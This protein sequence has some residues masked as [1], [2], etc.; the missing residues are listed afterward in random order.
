MNEIPASLGFRMPAEWERHEATWIAW[1]HEAT[2][3]PGKFAPIAW[4][5]GEIV[6]HLSRVERVRILVQDG[7]S[8][9]RI[10]GVL[11]KSG[12]D[13]DAVDFFPIKTDRSWT[14]DYCPIFVTNADGRR[15][16]LNWRFNGWAKYGNH[17]A[18]DAVTIGILFFLRRRL[19]LGRFA[20]DQRR[21]DA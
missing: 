8:E 1:P 4:V 9:R 14:R 2:D 6:R 21:G 7:A 10:R 13:L 19:G 12:A 17:R 20:A 15:G 16:V 5:Y 11:K 18:D 3:W